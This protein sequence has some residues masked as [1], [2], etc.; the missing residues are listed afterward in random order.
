MLQCFK[1]LRNTFRLSLATNWGKYRRMWDKNQ[2]FYH[3]P[4]LC[5][6]SFCNPKCYPQSFLLMSQQPGD[7]CSYV[8][9]SKLLSE[10]HARLIIKEGKR[11]LRIYFLFKQSFKVCC[12]TMN[13]CWLEGQRSEREKSDRKLFAKCSQRTWQ[14]KQKPGTGN[15]IQPF[16]L[17][18]GTQVLDNSTSAFHNVHYQEAVIGNQITSSSQITWGPDGEKPYLSH[19]AGYITKITSLKEPW[20][21]CC[22]SNYGPFVMKYM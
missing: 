6:L 2:E 7:V 4:V 19:S 1:I 11:N 9:N 17:V 10:K 18:T 12:I 15:S 16:T 8:K 21:G 5:W 22:K 3:L 20:D 13:I 14:D